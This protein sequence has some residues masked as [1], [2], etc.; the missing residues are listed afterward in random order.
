MESI[1][2]C[3]LT[4]FLC[5]YF[6]YFW[7]FSCFSALTS[8]AL[9]LISTVQTMLRKHKTLV[10]YGPYITQILDV[11]YSS[12]FSIRELRNAPEVLEYYRFQCVSVR[13][14]CVKG[15]QMI[16]SVDLI[17]HPVSLWLPI[18]YCVSRLH[19]SQGKCGSTECHQILVIIINDAMH[20]IFS[21]S[22]SIY[23]VPFAGLPFVHSLGIWLCGT[24]CDR[25]CVMLNYL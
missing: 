24:E 4:C 7:V 5:I 21:N 18:I 15:S 11:S 14:S 2:P 22:E 23:S 25:V 12:N 3:L 19:A 10:S 1:H 16:L 6:F 13:V 17:C 8:K 20:I 9:L